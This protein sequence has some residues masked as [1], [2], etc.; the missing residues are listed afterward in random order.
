MNGRNDD[1]LMN[2]R[3]DDFSSFR[4][5]RNRVVISSHLF[6]NKFFFIFL[7]AVIV[8]GCSPHRDRV[9]FPQKCVNVEIAQ[10]PTERERGLQFRER[11]GKDEGMLFIFQVPG[12]ERFWMKDTLIPLDMIWID[13]NKDVIDITANVPPCTAD[14]CASYGPEA[15]VAYVLEVNAGSAARWGLRVGDKTRMTK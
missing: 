9:C 12:P 6:M 10:T 8:L 3:I 1:E 13:A 14:P 4:Q 11:L 7:L 15:D 5:N 2:G